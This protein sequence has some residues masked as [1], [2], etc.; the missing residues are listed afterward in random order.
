MT[1]ASSC[2]VKRCIHAFTGRKR[3]LIQAVAL[4]TGI[5][6]GGSLAFG[7]DLAPRAYLITPSGANAVTLSYSFN[8]GSVFVDPSLPI[9]DL[10]ITFQTQ[11]ISY[12]RSL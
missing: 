6:C 4:I 11:A 1:R 9:E 2:C 3:I 12:Y 10:K 5:C 8:D 7:Q